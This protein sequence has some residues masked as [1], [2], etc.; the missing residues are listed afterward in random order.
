MSATQAKYDRLLRL[1]REATTLDSVGRLLHWDQETHMPPEGAPIRAQQTEL[2]AGLVHKRRT[3]AAFRGA[4]EELVDLESGKLH[5]ADLSRAQRAALREWRRDFLLAT[6]LPARWV[7]AFAAITSESV[8]V[9]RAAREHSDFAKFAPNLE[10]LLDLWREKAELLGYARHPYDA[11]LD[12]YEPGA[13]VAT[14]RPLFQGLRPPLVSLRSELA[15][16]PPAKRDFLNKRYPKEK[17]M[18]FGRELLTCTGFTDERGAL[19]LTTHPFCTSLHPRDGRVTTRVSERDPMENFLAIMHEGG[20]YLYEA[21]LPENHFG[22]PLCEAVSMA[23]HES[24]SRWWETLVGQ[25]WPFWQYAL[26]RLKQVFP[27]QLK[28]ISL[29]AFYAAINAPRQTPIRI[30]ADEVSYCLHI[31]L[32]F[33]LECGLLEGSIQ[34]SDIPEAWNSHMKSLLGLTPANAAQGCLQDVHWSCG[35]M[36]YFPTYALGNLYAAQFFEAFAKAHPNWSERVAAGE[37]EFMRD[38]LHQQIHRYGRQYRSAEL[39]RK[40]TGKVPSPN[41]YLAYLDAKYRG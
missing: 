24:Q 27:S 38:W 22:S 16:R 34:V 33:E 3:S 28:E 10:R 17:Q 36:G 8:E 26:P 35:H 6:R 32:R 19:D 20:H 37:F 1:S 14:L 40:V 13:T 7:K 39:M 31:I 30:Q 4:L 25:S 15:E 21:N 18:A 11:L 2:I 23:V 41:P 12:E 29:E 9:W 5:T